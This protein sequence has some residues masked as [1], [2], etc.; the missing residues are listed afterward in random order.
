MR[1]LL[2]LGSSNRFKIKCTYYYWFDLHSFTIRQILDGDF[3]K[4]VYIVCMEGGGRKSGG[5][6]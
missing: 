4:L 6:E 3:T 2:I 1:Q 5:V